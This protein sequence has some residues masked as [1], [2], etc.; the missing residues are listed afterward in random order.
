MANGAVSEPE[1][2]L[3]AA[4]LEQRVCAYYACAWEAHLVMPK[5]VA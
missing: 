2:M 1:R 3:S 4:E 5:K